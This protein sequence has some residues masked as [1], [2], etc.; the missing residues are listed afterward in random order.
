MIIVFFYEQIS[1]EAKIFYFAEI[2]TI[3][4]GGVL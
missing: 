2:G 1:G 3:G 4:S